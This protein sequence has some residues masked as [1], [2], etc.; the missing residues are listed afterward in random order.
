VRETLL[1][2]AQIVSM[3]DEGSEANNK[4]PVTQLLRMLSSVPPDLQI[5]GQ[6]PLIQPDQQFP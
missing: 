3:Y 2:K 5:M 4:R 6:P 1:S